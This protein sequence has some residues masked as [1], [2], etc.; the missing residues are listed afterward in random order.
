MNALP[1]DEPK[2]IHTRRERARA[3]PGRQR[4]VRR[5]AFEDHLE[6]GEGESN[7]G[8]Q[9]AIEGVEHHGGVDVAEHASFEHL[10]FAPAAFLG[11]SAEEIDGTAELVAYV[12]K[13]QESAERA[14][15]DEIVPA[16][17]PEIGK[18]VV[19][20]ENGDLGMA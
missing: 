9:I 14:G 20:R 4:R 13:S 11:R 19:L 15:G 17:V 5:F 1:V 3:V 2:R 12:V 8:N 10:D 7:M 6:M 16:G 18:S